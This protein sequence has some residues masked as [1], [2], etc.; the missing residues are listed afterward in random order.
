MWGVA[1]RKFCTIGSKKTSP[2]RAVYVSVSVSGLTQDKARNPVSTVVREA[3]G[4]HI[5]GCQTNYFS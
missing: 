4:M 1:D 5:S 2:E 3:R